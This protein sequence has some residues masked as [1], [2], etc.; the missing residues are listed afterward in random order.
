MV[1]SR[2]DLNFCVHDRPS[3]RQEDTQTV[4]E[5]Q[6]ERERQTDRQTEREPIAKTERQ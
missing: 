2:G 1:F 5:R 4:T 6:R 3:R